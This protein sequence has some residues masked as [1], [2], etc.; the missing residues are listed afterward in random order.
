MKIRNIELINRWLNSLL[1]LEQWVDALDE[2]QRKLLL[3]AMIIGATLLSIILCFMPTLAEH[4]ALINQKNQ[5]QTAAQALQTVI[6]NKKESE[7]NNAKIGSGSSTTV[8]RKLAITPAVPGLFRDFVEKN[9]RVDLIQLSISPPVKIQEEAKDFLVDGKAV[10]RTELTLVISG[11]FNDIFNYMQKL[12]NMPWYYF[13][14]S[15]SYEV[16]KY[17]EATVV[18]TLVVFSTAAEKI[19]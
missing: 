16:T 1:K 9:S 7:E 15:M 10:Y 11:S 8:P 3:T 12:D 5:L 17:P 19:A 4:K 18:L 13:W 14:Q 2:T 6:Q